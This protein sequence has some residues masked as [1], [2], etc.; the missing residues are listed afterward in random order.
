MRLQENQQLAAEYRRLA[1]E[2]LS[3]QQRGVQD[4]NQTIDLVVA[5]Y[6]DANAGILSVSPSLD[7]LQIVLTTSASGGLCRFGSVRHASGYG[8]PTATTG[9][10]ARAC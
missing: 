10:G 7:A 5:S 9:W 8:P 3:A 6:Q 2:A 4:M 1:S